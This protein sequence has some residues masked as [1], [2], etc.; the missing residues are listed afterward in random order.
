MLTPCFVQFVWKSSLNFHERTSHKD[1]TNAT[2]SSFNSEGTSSPD[3]IITKTE[4][5][6]TTQHRNVPPLQLQHCRTT[7]PSQSILL[8]ESPVEIQH[9]RRI[10]PTLTEPLALNSQSQRIPELHIPQAYHQSSVFCPG[11]QLDSMKQADVPN[12][13]YRT[14]FTSDL[15]SICKPSTSS[16]PSSPVVQNPVPN[17][18][19]FDYTG[20]IGEIQFPNPIFALPTAHAKSERDVNQALST[21][22]EDELIHHDEI[23]QGLNHR[24]NP[25]PIVS[26]SSP[27][28]QSSDFH[29]LSPPTSP[30]IHA[31]N[32]RNSA[33]EFQKHDKMSDILVFDLTD[34]WPNESILPPEE[35]GLQLSTIGHHIHN[36][37]EDYLKSNELELKINVKEESSD[38]TPLSKQL[39]FGD[40]QQ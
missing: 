8:P 38:D 4:P 40:C 9:A 29:I 23:H 6:T 22:L 5:V 12:H 33:D 18:V 2:I 34:S 31:T 7:S 14:Q 30:H 28:E 27:F 36:G 16:H 32:S 3:H 35:L 10:A 1:G 21:K 20:D 26:V 15:G 17:N 19:I 24:E 37:E 39:D 13:L 11:L 25:N